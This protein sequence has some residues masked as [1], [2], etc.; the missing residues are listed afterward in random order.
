MHETIAQLSQPAA[1]GTLTQEAALE[2]ALA[3]LQLERSERLDPSR[4]RLV[5]L[6]LRSLRNDLHA[7]LR[8]QANDSA[9]APRVS[10][11]SFGARAQ[12]PVTVAG[13]RLTG[14]IDLVEQSTSPSERPLLRATD[15]KTGRI[16]EELEHDR[17]KG[18]FIT[19]GGHILQP[20][21]YALALEQLYPEAD[22]RAGRLYYCTRQEQFESFVVELNERTRQ[23]AAQVAQSASEL[24]G[25]GFLPADPERDACGRCEYQVICGPHEAERVDQV[26]KRD[27]GRLRSLELLR[28]QP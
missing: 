4:A 14:A 1:A 17:P 21:L 20:L 6:E 3:Q 18:R 13:L 7:I 26:K 12:A 16:P 10:E 23:V 28:R 8:D 27:R 24:I 15:F 19:A 11:L 22:V 2:H 9:W 5:E 25:Q